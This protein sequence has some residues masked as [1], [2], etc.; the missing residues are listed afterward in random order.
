MKKSFSE[1]LGIAES[2]PMLQTDGMNETLRN[3]IWNIFY[4]LFQDYRSEYW[5]SL[6]E[7]IAHNFRKYPV[8]ELPEYDVRCREW[9]KEYFYSLPWNRQYELVE[10][11]VENYNNILQYSNHNRKKLEGMF[12]GIFEREMSGYR[13][14]AGVL[15]PISNP[16]ETMEISGAIEMTSRIG[17]DGAHHHLQAALSLLAKKP[18][19]DYRNSIKE[20]ISA[21]ES[22]A[23]TLGKENSKGLSDALDELSK[24]TNLHAA[25]RAGFNNL[26]GYTSDEDGI[27]H[28]ILEEPNV[29]FDEAKYMV[30]SCS[31]FV[32][33]LIAKADAAGLLSK[34]VVS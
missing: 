26:Y 5:I 20:S 7:W 27:R 8:D 6:A 19:P 9:I 13:F 10:F 25:L 21:V 29:G 22:V 11:V 2:V 23:K 16:A 31:A 18:E 24:K 15:A 32:N 4:S 3:S 12:N 34:K 14:I 28:A 17:L 1:R 30:V 33:Y